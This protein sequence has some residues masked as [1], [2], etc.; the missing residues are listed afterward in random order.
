MFAK[1]T[2]K[3]DFTPPELL[4]CVN[5]RLYI[6]FFTFYAPVCKDFRSFVAIF[7]EN[8]LHSL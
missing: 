3:A 2:I 6:L 7:T 8:R 5:N 4:I 1:V